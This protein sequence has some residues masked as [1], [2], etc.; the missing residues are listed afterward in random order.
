M[1]N[2][3]NVTAYVRCDCVPRAGSVTR[4]CTVCGHRYKVTDKNILFGHPKCEK[5]LLSEL[6]AEIEPFTL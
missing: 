6:D 2:E 4:V 5:A 1:K 3:D